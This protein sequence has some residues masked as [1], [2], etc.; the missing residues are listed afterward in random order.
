MDLTDVCRIFDP[1]RLYF[2][3]STPID[4]SP[5]NDYILSRKAILKRHKKIGIMPCILSKNAID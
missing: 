4:P 2:L 3:L 5:K 1:K